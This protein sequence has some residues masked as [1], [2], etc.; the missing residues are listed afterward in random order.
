MVKA[1]APDESSYRKPF[2]QG[3]QHEATLRTCLDLHA[4]GAATAATGC[5][6]TRHQETS[7]AYVTTRRD[8]TH[9]DKFAEDPT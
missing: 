7:G 4:V 3:E 5:S 1:E 8:H 2:G 6:V 9:Q